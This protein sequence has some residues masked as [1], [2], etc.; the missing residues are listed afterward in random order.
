MSSLDLMLS[1]LVQ[2]V[3][4]GGPVFFLVALLTFALWLLLLERMVYFQRSLVGDLDHYKK[5]WQK[6]GD[7]QSRGAQQI[8]S[9]LLSALNGRIDRYLPTIKTL[10]SVA[11]LLG[12]L[13][14]VTGMVGV[15]DA[16]SWQGGSTQAMSS[17]IARATIPTMAGLVAALSGVIGLTVVERQARRARSRAAAALSLEARGVSLPVDVSQVDVSQVHI[18]NGE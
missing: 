16:M 18:S 2:L 11:P 14:T 7:R 13:G 3:E 12:L 1:Q 6:R 8:R 17:G 9:A 5:V 10:V 4:R 15:F